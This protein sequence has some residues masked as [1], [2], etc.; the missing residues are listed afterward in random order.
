MDKYQTTLN[1]FLTDAMQGDSLTDS[2]SSLL[3]TISKVCISI[4]EITAK[5]ALAGVTGKLES[6]NIQGE[7][8]MQLD[9]LT[10]DLFINALK[11]CG[12]VAGLAS[13][14]E[15]EIQAI[16]NAE[17]ARFLVVFDPLDGSSNVPINVTVG[18]IFSVLKASKTGALCEA[19]FLQAGN[20]QLAAGYVLYG[21]ATMLVLTVG[22]GTHGFTLD[23]ESKTFILTHPNMQV[24]EITS[25][26][27]INAS[28]ERYWDAPIVRYVDECKAGIAGERERDFNMRW[29]ASMVADVHRILIRGGIYLYPRDNK[30]PAKAGR[31]RLMYE[32]NPMSMLVE[33]A[34][35]KS[36]TGSQRIM[37]VVPESIHQRISVIIGT[38]NEVSLVERYTLAYSSGDA[39]LGMSPLFGIRSLFQKTQ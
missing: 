39:R 28:N 12:L 19:D 29:V 7:T 37:D 25:E 32:A 22:Q 23:T 14:E 3:L 8:Q 6:Q 2:L 1:L 4:A 27:A 18:S 30:K 17:E 33:Q 31:L 15:E 10:N 38:S 5:G 13:E 24:A 34:G 21:P 35:G 26:F 36:S 9:V 11:D 16:S 20:Q